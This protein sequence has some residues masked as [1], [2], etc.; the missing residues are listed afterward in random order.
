MSHERPGE[1]RTA[2]AAPITVRPYI[3]ADEPA[4]LEVLIASLGGGPAGR[5]PPEF[6]RWKHYDNPFGRSFMLVAESE[7]RIVGVR[8]LMR[9]RF[10]TDGRLVHAVRAVDTATH[11]EW[12]GRGLFTR[13]TMEA[14]E[15]LRADT[16]F[17]FNTPNHKSLP[18]YLKMGWQ[19][20]EKVPVAVKVRRPLHFAR[21]VRTLND[22][23]P[24]STSH[25]PVE[26]ATASEALDL[27]GI[28]ALLE[29]R[30]MGRRMR[31]PRDLAYVR[32]RYGAAPL[33]DYR[34]VVDSDGSGVTGL[35]IFRVRPRGA[36]WE[37]TV[38]ELIAE[39]GDMGICRRLLR[40]VASASPVDHV[41]CHFP[42]GSVQASAARRLGFLPSPG[43]MTF[44]V[45]PLRD[46]LPLDP[47]EAES[48]ALSLGDLEAF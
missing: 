37:S 13:L 2:T 24:P 33:L 42:S 25:P 5:R 11:P 21:G 28:E 12:Q 16:D 19:V 3:D 27:D 22:S 41:T 44:V 48:W 20:V 36:L 8:A 43:G 9:W 4:A 29:A 14:I 47:R 30:N 31:T 45:N 17:I 35:A 7:E 32:W 46:G 40:A 18:G 38:C 10:E 34:A 23:V 39:D 26:A 15:G 1:A 6:F